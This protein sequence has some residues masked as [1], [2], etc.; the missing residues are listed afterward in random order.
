MKTT[1]MT[2]LAIAVALSTALGAR[3]QLT[4]TELMQ[5]NITY[6]M[7]DLNDFPDSWVELY[8]AGDETEQLGDYHIGL[9][10][11]IAS[12]DALPAMEIMPGEYV[13]INCD[14]AATGLH[15]S[16]RLESN[17]AGDVYLFKNGEQI[18]HVAHPIFPAP[19]IA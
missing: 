4:I 12:A 17:K 6:C 1:K 8:N 9:K 2:G 10:K 14:K 15:T 5:S 18:D 16:F 7:D 3:G 19:N 11:K 13:I